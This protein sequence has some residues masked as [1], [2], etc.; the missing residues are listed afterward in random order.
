MLTRLRPGQLEDA[1]PCR[2]DQEREVPVWR[3]FAFDRHPVP[4]VGGGQCF[5]Q[6]SVYVCVKGEKD[7]ECSKCLYH[8]PPG[9]ETL[10]LIL[11]YK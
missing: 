1:G 6:T 4:K 11:I 5:W 7:K 3:S 2:K 10:C 8:P 9:Y